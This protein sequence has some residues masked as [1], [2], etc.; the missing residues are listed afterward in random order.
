[1][2]SLLFASIPDSVISNSCT[3]VTGAN[4]PPLTIRPN[5]VNASFDVIV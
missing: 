2:F 5:A 3:P 4:N 1:M